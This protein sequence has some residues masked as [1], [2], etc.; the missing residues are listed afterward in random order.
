MDAFKPA[1]WYAYRP[2][3]VAVYM[4]ASRFALLKLLKVDAWLYAELQAP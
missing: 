4:H 3:H 2:R 1:C